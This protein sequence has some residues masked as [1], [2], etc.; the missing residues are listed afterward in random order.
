[1]ARDMYFPDEG[2]PISELLGM[3]VGKQ[4][5]CKPGKQLSPTSETLG[6]QGVYVFDDGEIAAVILTDMGFSSST[7][8]ALSMLNARLAEEAMK[9]GELDEVMRENV[10]EVLNIGAS[11]F[12]APYRPHVKFREQAVAPETLPG[13]AEGVLFDYDRR[14]DLSVEIAGYPAGTISILEAA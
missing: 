1:M 5:S 12:N 2:G 14:L 4:V 13:D 6:A 7:G 9:R 10:Q 11:W 8:A 3:L